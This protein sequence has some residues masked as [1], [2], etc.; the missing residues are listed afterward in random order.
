MALRIQK[1]KHKCNFHYLSMAMM[2]PQILKS[3]DF[4]KTK[5]CKNLEIKTLYFLKIKAV[6]NYTSRATV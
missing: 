2:V 3:V 5:K 4:I 6:V 1:N